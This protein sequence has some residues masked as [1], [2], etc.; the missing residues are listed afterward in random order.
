M[1]A[2]ITRVKKN[3]NHFYVTSGLMLRTTS[4]FIMEMEYANDSSIS[5][6]E[7]LNIP[8]LVLRYQFKLPAFSCLDSTADCSLSSDTNE[9]T[10]INE[11]RVHDVNIW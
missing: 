5:K 8:T 6:A 3:R 11:L 10:A 2:T 1:R 4:A 9:D 7:E